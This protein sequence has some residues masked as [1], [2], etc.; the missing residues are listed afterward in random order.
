MTTAILK[1]GLCSLIACT[2]DDNESAEKFANRE[3]PTGI[4]SRWQIVIK[5]DGTPDVVTCEQDPG[6]RHLLMEC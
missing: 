3:Y 5:D 1:A 4:S 6:R 2:D